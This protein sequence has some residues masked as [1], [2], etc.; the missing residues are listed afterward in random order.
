MAISLNRELFWRLTASSSANRNGLLVLEVCDVALASF[1]SLSHRPDSPMRSIGSSK[2]AVVVLATTS[3]C[4]IR[5][6]TRREALA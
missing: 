3:S 4:S 1:A 2:A 6:L 5:I